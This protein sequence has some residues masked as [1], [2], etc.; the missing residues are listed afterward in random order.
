MIFPSKFP[1]VTQMNLVLISGLINKE[2]CKLV[3]FSEK[4]DASGEH[5]SENRKTFQNLLFGKK[6]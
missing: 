5:N 2:F 1:E 4:L 3:A 6:K